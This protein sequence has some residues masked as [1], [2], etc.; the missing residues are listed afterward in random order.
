M[1]VPNSIRVDNGS[2]FVSKKFKGWCIKKEI[3]IW[4]TQLGRPMQNGYIKKIQ[5]DF[6]RKYSRCLPI[7]GHCPISAI[8]R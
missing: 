3:V 6:Q 7:R 4:H 5:L 2:E 1:I 8:S